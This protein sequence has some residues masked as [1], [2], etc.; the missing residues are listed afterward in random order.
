MRLA[1]HVERIGEIGDQA[2]ADDLADIA[3]LTG[4]RPEVRA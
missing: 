4:W 1:R 3:K 2:V